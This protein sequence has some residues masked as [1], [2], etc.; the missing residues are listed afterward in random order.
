MGGEPQQVYAGSE[1]DALSLAREEREPCEGVEDR[2]CGGNRRMLGAWMRRAGH[3]QW[4]NEVLGHPDRFETEPLG[5]PAG[6]REVIGGVER[7]EGDS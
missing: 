7:P 6:H 5:L 4:K 3:G 2:R 1:A